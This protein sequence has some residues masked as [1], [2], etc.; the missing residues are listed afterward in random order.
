LVTDEQIPWSREASSR[1]ERDGFVFY[2][3]L[4]PRLSTLDVARHFGSV[5][6]IDR[7]LPSSGIP[8]IQ[9]LVPRTAGEAPKNRYS[10]HYG[11]NAFPLHTDLAHWAIPPRYFLLRCLAGSMNVETK[12]LPANYIVD[13]L[14]KACLQKAILR[15]R[16][17]RPGSSGLLRA[18]G[19]LSQQWLFRWDAV[20]LEPVNHHA[21]TLKNMMEG[22][23]FDG[24]T[25]VCLQDRGDTL[26]LD[27]WRLLHGRGAVPF[28][29]ARQ[30]ER[31]Y[32]SR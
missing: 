28:G 11:L 24:I 16:K 31:V 4:N 9:S 3:K 26:L 10:G 7:M 8:T 17:R 29:S 12:L 5:I 27:N 1:L 20:F 2:K 25:G 14:G 22:C 18:L 23:L 15:V 30:I 6:E 21:I 32:L 19:C 13:R